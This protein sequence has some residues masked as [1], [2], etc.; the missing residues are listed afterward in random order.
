MYFLS[1]VQALDV[2]YG[3]SNIF[4]KWNFKKAS[5][6]YHGLNGQK[7]MFELFSEIMKLLHAAAFSVNIVSI[8]L[9]RN[10]LLK[11]CQ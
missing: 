1:T 5:F 2:L 6:P 7:Y 4:V 10:F 9:Q 3:H 8:R 11:G